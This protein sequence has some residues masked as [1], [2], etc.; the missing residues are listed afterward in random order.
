MAERILVAYATT[1]GSTGEIAGV[2]ADVL[3]NQ[4]MDVELQLLGK[5][6][7]LDGYKAIVMGAP[8]YMFHW[9]NDARNF[10]NKN[11]QM[12]ENKLPAA[13]FAG[14]IIS[15]EEGDEEE[16]VRQQMK[17]ELAKFPWFHPVSVQIVGGRFDPN[18][19]KFPYTLIPALKKMP[20][21]DYRNWE[22]IRSWADSLVE[23]LNPRD[24]KM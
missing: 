16:S 8:L 12:L 19:L 1:S 10:L 2:V 20:V 21:A 3:K 4:G 24:A 6:R 22:E 11:R 15:T 23:M 18:L 14:G 9:H 13:V 5:V 17:K 7:G